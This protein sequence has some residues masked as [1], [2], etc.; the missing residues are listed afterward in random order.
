MCDRLIAEKGPTLV[1]MVIN[2]CLETPGR[3][4]LAL[5]KG[6]CSVSS[7]SAGFG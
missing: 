3:S 2:D 1:P 7:L 5:E 4:D 6:H